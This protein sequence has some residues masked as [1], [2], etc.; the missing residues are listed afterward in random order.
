MNTTQQ[1]GGATSEQLATIRAMRVDDVARAMMADG[2]TLSWAQADAL[3]DEVKVVTQ[4]RRV[5][6]A[7]N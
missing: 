1:A 5:T 3:S 4:L 6:F 7:Q 2:V